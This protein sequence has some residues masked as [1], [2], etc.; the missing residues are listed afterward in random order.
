[1]AD[2]NEVHERIAVRVPV[3]RAYLAWT[4][5][6]QFP[7]FMD[8]IESVEDLGDMRYRW[9]ARGP[10]GATAEW[11]A[12]ITENIPNQIIAWRTD[13]DASL[14]VNGAVR[15]QEVSPDET[16]IDVNM[17]Y[18]A[19]GAGE[20]IAKLFEKP[21][22]Q[23]REDLQ[24]FKVY[25]EADISP[26]LASQDRAP[27]ATGGTMTHRTA[28]EHDGGIERVAMA[29]SLREF[30][31]ATAVADRSIPLE[32]LEPAVPDEQEQREIILRQLAEQR[33][34][35]HEGEALPAAEDTIG[36]PV[37]QELA[38]AGETTN[39]EQQPPTKASTGRGEAA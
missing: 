12:R 22:E 9:K 2:M 19:G 31:E 37:E 26:Q 4:Q 11:D 25:V 28:A 15:F 5:F 27:A 10:M 20:A 32:A 21:E 34:E 14:R 6:D 1:M 7:T 23:V 36:E 30:D 38:R 16:L 35:L 29:E 8:N 24:R 39:P 13:D 18:E 17:G 3:H 33:A